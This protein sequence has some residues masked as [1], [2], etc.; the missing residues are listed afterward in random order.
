MDHRYQG[1]FSADSRRRKEGM[2]GGDF[3]R[4]LSLANCGEDRSGKVQTVGGGGLR[5]VVVR[6]VAPC[7]LS[8]VVRVTERDRAIAASHGL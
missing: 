8:T 2:G 3:R 5:L 1:F 4:E 7:D 6:R